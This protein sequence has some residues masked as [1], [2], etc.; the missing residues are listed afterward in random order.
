[1]RTVL[2]WKHRLQRVSN[3]TSAIV[4]SLFLLLALEF[5]LASTIGY[6]FGMAQVI[7]F[8]SLIS[9]FSLM[10]AIL[11]LN[12][13]LTSGNKMKY[14]IL[15]YPL[16][17]FQEIDQPANMIVMAVGK[18]DVLDAFQVWFDGDDVILERVQHASRVEHE[19]FLFYRY[20]ICKA[21]FPG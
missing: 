18:N 6:S 7:L 10:R 19:R 2:V 5:A 1:M 21:M 14:G 11:S 3:Y 20:V 9:F 17:G 13:D 15:A 8:S 12:T 4:V 16:T